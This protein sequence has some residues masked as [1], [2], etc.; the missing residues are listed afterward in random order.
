[1]EQVLLAAGG[2]WQLAWAFAVIFVAYALRGAT[3]FGAGVVSIPL[4][5]LALP[6]QVVIPLVT[7]MGMLASFAQAVHQRHFIDWQGLRGLLVP[8]VIG[9][10]AGLWLF[11]SLDPEL[12]LRALAV[13]II[14]YA[15]WGYLPRRLARP[16]PAWLAPLAGALGGFVATV[17]GGM[18]GP[19]YAVYLRTR[20]LDK[21]MFR[22]TMAFA[23]VSLSVLRAAGYGGLGFY[24]ARVLWLLAAALPVLVVAMIAGDRWHARLDEARFGHVVAALLV[25][26]GAALLFK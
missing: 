4:L 24:D 21:T 3:G 19:L 25:L 10:A 5:L 23:L 14:G 1:M 12:L 9:V 11:K 13:F 15:L 26:S 2:T 6:L 17:F 20:A 18:A 8:S 7:A 22:A 16:A